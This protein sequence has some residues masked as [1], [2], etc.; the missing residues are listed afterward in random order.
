MNWLNRKSTETKYVSKDT[1]E[2]SGVDTSTAET[3]TVEEIEKGADFMSTE[4]TETENGKRELVVVERKETTGIGIFGIGFL[5]WA[6]TTAVCC[7][8][9]KVTDLVKKGSQE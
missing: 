9:D 1:L 3:T 6:G 5:I 8:L 7:I 2:E 4:T